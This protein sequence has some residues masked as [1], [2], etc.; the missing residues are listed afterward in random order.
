MTSVAAGPVT[1]IV[2]ADKWTVRNMVLTLDKIRQLWFIV[3]RH[4]TLFSDLTRGDF[5]NFVR[6]LLARNTMWFEVWEYDVIIGIIW[7]TDLE[8]VTDATI[9]M[10]FFDRRPLEK[11]GV[12]RALL[13][14]AFTEMPLQR[15][16]VTPPRIYKHTIRLCERMG[17]KLE[18]CKRSALLMGGQWQDQFFYGITRK[19]VEAL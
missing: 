5:E 12:C 19:E 9:H 7:L 18:G 10:A 11:V 1:Y 6:A 13:K 3:Q 14:W 15:L 2:Q 8:L 16:S 4:R 17:F